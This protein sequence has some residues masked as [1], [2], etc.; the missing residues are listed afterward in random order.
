M[1]KHFG[2]NII[3]DALR[4]REEGRTYLLFFLASGIL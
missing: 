4:M 3:K 2:Q 1:S